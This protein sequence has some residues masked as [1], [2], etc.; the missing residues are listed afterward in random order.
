MTARSGT[1]VSMRRPSVKGALA[2]LALVALQS[3][4]LSQIAAG[5]TAGIVG[6]GAIALQ[7][8]A[9]PELVEAAIPGSIGTLEA[10]MITIPENQVLRLSLAKSY[11]SLGFGFLV[12]HM[13]QAQQADDVD[14]ADHYRARA[15]A[16]FLRARTI[17]FEIMSIWEPDDGGVN[18]NR[19]SVERW[20]NYLRNFERR[21]MGGQL[22]WTAY[23][24]ANY[25]NLNKDDPDAVADLP[26]VLA[27]G[28]R[29]K[30]LDHE[31]N[32]YA[33]HALLA[34]LQAATPAALG[35]RPD[36]AQREFEWL[37]QTT[38]G[39]NL[40]YSVIYARNV[41]VPLQNRRGYQEQLQAVLD[42]GDVSEDNRL[43]N[44]LAKRRARRYLA[45]VDDLF[46][47]DEPSGTPSGNEATAASD[48][49]APAN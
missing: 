33:P 13:E 42:A 31:Y 38:R 28:E 24:W 22:F 39:T 43:Q 37:I 45:Q 35:G 40:M 46:L 11:C 5:S 7:R 12:D 36:L 41:L 21:E 34:G 47:P 6:R 49:A 16:A 14:R 32:D 48:T 44:L 29:A 10:L 23:A 30:D 27:L 18:G 26:Y 9:D 4:C 20:R 1:A 8:A 25:I 3:G 17:G 15:S 19:R 2:M